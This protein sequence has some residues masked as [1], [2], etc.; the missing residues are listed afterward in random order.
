MDKIWRRSDIIWFS[1]CDVKIRWNVLLRRIRQL[2][3]AA[4]FQILFIF[5]NLG[6]L[7]FPALLVALE[8]STTFP[9]FFSE[10]IRIEKCGKIPK[11]QKVREVE[12]PQMS[13]SNFGCLCYFFQSIFWKIVLL[14]VKNIFGTFVIDLVVLKVYNLVPNSYRCLYFLKWRRVTY[15]LNVNRKARF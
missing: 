8:S 9:H 7:N 10:K 6:H 14:L 12:L 13:K 3:I 11:C 4:K 1:W 5:W 15:S 2:H